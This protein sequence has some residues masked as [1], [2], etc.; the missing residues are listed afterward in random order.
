M[1]P[2]HWTNSDRILTAQQP[3]VPLIVERRAANSPCWLSGSRPCLR[4]LHL[5]RTELLWSGVC[6]VSLPIGC[7]SIAPVHRPTETGAFVR[8]EAQ[9][10]LVEG[11]ERTCRCAAL[12]N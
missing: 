6:F 5:L 1:E 2:L 10:P 12:N 4:S 3:L 8:A 9:L 7:P 11:V